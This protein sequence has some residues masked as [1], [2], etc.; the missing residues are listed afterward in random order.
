MALSRVNSG[1]TIQ[2]NQLNQYFDLLT[3]V[4]TD[5]QVILRGNASGGESGFPLRIQ[6]SN[7][8]DNGGGIQLDAPNAVT[9]GARARLF[10]HNL[11]GR[12]ALSREPVGGSPT[13]IFRVDENGRAQ[14]PL[15]DYYLAGRKTGS[16]TP[17]T[18]RYE[19]VSAPFSTI[20]DNILSVTL[21]PQTGFS[22]IV[23]VFLTAERTSPVGEMGNV[24]VISK[25]TTSIQ[26][27]VHIGGSGGSQVT[28]IL[29]AFVIG[30]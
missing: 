12:L 14:G 8:Y 16:H 23:A 27:K 28:G 6:A 17:D 21:T 18:Y 4:M 13:E 25:S 24:Y 7:A 22:T 3:G 1:D 20:G 30:T 2:V 11:R 29:W 15:N 5:Q 9:S 10:V 26:A 19:I